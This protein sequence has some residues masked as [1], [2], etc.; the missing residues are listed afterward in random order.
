MSNGIVVLD[1]SAVL[2]LLQNEAG[3]DVVAKMLP[4]GA[5][6][7]VNLSE[8]LAKL[9]GHGM[10]AGDARRARWTVVGHS[11]VRSRSGVRRRRTP[12]RHTRR[13]AVIGRPGLPRFGRETRRGGGYGGSRMGLARR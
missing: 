9:T 13:R 4:R 3:A 5:M 7:A 2:A 8:I 6:S 11:F 10:P 1:A 12:P